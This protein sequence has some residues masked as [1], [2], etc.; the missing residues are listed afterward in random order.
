MSL[1]DPI[2]LD[3]GPEFEVEAILHH[4]WVGHH[5][6]KLEFLVSI[7]DY[8]S[9]HNKW[10]PASHLANALYILTAYKALHGLT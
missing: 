4:W 1:P 10:L 5:Q 2:E 6:S 9:S 7:L 8:D 3:T